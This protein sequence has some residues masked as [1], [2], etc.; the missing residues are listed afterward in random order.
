MA[1]WAKPE[2]RLTGVESASSLFP[3]FE[4][5]YIGPV[6]SGCEGESAQLSPAYRGRKSATGSAVPGVGE[7][8]SSQLSSLVDVFHHWCHERYK[9]QSK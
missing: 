8:G 9:P 1:V 7:V 6:G 3:I 5:S 2:T 4:P